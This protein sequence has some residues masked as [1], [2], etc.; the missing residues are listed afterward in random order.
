MFT[1]SRL[2]HLGL[3]AMPSESVAP[4]SISSQV[5]SSEYLSR[6]G[7]GLPVQNPQAAQNRQAG[8]LQNRELPRERGEVACDLT[9]PKTKPRFF[10]PPVGLGLLAGSS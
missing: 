7:L 9:P 10:L 2:K 6:P 3:L 8:V 5:S 1:Y 4:A